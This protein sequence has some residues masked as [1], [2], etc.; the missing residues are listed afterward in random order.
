VSFFFLSFFLLASGVHDNSRKDPGP[1]EESE[2]L[3]ETAIA[4]PVFKGIGQ[5]KLKC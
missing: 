3:M 1:V 2:M 5:S 4:E